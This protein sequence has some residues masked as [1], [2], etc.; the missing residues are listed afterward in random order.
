MKPY[1]LF[2]AIDS[3]LEINGAEKVLR[4]VEALVNKNNG[5]FLKT[6]FKAKQ[7]LAYPIKGEHDA[8]QY[9]IE[10][11]ADPSAIET[12]KRQLTITNE[13]HR[14]GIFALAK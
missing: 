10:F 11:E 5:R 14:Y 12:I 6:D 4:E 3:K 9:F 7:R 2:L 8:Y 13:V 1:E